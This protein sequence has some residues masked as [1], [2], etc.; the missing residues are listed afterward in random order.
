MPLSQVPKRVVYAIKRRFERQA[1][2]GSR[3]VVVVQE[4]VT[5]AAVRFM[6]GRDTVSS[7]ARGY[8]SGP[9]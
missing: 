9:R 8:W 1:E 5:V 2:D 7:C 6:R 4:T 3:W